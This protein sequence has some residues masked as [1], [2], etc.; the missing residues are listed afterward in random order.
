LNLK[1]A[2]AFS[3]KFGDVRVDLIYNAEHGTASNLLT[4]IAQKCGLST[5]SVEVSVKALRSLIAE[6]G[7]PD[8]VGL[9]I[10]LSHSQGGQISYSSVER[11]TSEEQ[12]MIATATFGTA[13]I[14][15]N[16][17]TFDSM[18]YISTNDAIPAIA[19]TLTYGMAKMGMVPNVQ[20]IR[21]KAE[22]SGRYFDH[23]ILGSTYEEALDVYRKRCEE[24][25][26]RRL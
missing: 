14:H 6:V 20:F 2:E 8:S 17:G 18:N 9:V 24:Y 13:K 26:I 21:S 5:H 11:L 16:M 22:G 3:E 23:K 25:L 10:S 1:A 12:R 4:T 7:G 19:D 15:S